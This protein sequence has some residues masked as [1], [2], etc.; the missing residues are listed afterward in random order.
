MA[1]A[2]ATPR[3]SSLT[4]GSDQTE[5]TAKR[6]AR[7]QKQ[8]EKTLIN[9]M[10]AKV[11]PN[12]GKMVKYSDIKSIT[13]LT[14]TQSAF[15]EAWNNNDADGF[16]LHGTVGTGKSFLAVYFALQEILMTEAEFKKLIIIRSSVPTRDMG[17][18][19]G[20]L[21][22]KMAVYEMP[23]IQICSELTNNK[24]AYEKLKETGKIEFMSSSFLRGTTF[25]D[26][27]ILVDE[28]QDLN[29]HEISTVISRIGKNSKLICCGD[30]KQDDLIKSK[31]D[32][33][34]FHNF[35][36][37]TRLMTEFRSFKFTV[38]DIVRSSFVK[39]FIVACEKLGL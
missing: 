38:D 24:F 20:D 17:F 22:E 15:F 2:P 36:A 23:Y 8:L 18:L 28:I 13:A 12:A 31:N 33:S 10:T 19:P 4:S 29:W 32:V 27:I 30:G 39:S 3:K 35:L 25:N 21:N 7:Q 1:R 34:G 26:A 6:L 37:V 11:A 9:E 5:R 16:I 14:D